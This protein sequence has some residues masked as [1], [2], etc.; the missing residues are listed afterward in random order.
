MARLSSLGAVLTLLVGIISAWL[1]YAK[2]ISDKQKDRDELQRQREYLDKEKLERLNSQY[3][4]VLAQVGQFLADEKVTTA[5]LIVLF[6]ELTDLAAARSD[7]QKRS[8]NQPDDAALLVANIVS[9][10]EFDF[11][12]YRNIEFDR[13]ALTFLSSYS[14]LLT[15]Q[16]PDLHTEILAKYSEALKLIND[17]NPSYFSNGVYIHGKIT[18]GTEKGKPI[19]YFHELGKVN[20]LAQYIGLSQGYKQHIDLLKTHLA[21]NPENKQSSQILDDAFC[22]FYWATNNKTLTENVFSIT[23]DDDEYHIFQKEYR[24]RCTAQ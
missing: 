5:S 15:E 17:S 3:R 4:A 12:Q 2:F 14:I 6:R 20:K 21:K 8:P 22:N 23:D 9:S 24:Q 18:V 13:K 10:L 7:L 1:A 11:K 19:V 16:R